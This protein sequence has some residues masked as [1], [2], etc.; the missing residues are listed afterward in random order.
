MMAHK[1]HKAGGRPLKRRVATR[2]P[3]KTLLI[4]C[5]GERTEPEYLDALKRQP[6]VRDVAAVD[7]RVETG[8]G[9]SVPQTLVSMAAAAR[10]KAIDEEAEID[11]F[12]CVFDVEWPRNHPGL[13]EA[14]GQAGQNGIQLAVSNPCFELWLIL[15]FQDQSAW[16]EK[17]RRTQAPPKTRRG[18]R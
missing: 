12:W 17:R 2:R 10:S 3:R 13:K 8:Q 15:H 5:E 4:F 6:S 1:S 11:E 14:I 7:L 18:Q 16:L 9:G